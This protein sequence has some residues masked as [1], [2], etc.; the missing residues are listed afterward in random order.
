MPRR[1]Y[2][3]PDAHVFA[4]PPSAALRQLGYA[5]RVIRQLGGNANMHWLVRHGD[6]VGGVAVL[7]RYGPWH[8]LDDVLYE[9]RVL[10]RVAAL[11]W[12]VPRALAYPKRLGRHWWCL[13]SYI[14][15]RQRR[16][17]TNAAVREE[18]RARG[19]LLAELH[20]DLAGLAGF[21]Q[22]PGWQRREEVL[23]PR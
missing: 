21:G 19:R 11:G 2:K 6:H 18:L 10:E 9:L 4:L 23:G 22:R 5:G 16:P 17:R 13:F 12:P 3:V 14:R 8:E 7:R 1:P 20:T 15:G